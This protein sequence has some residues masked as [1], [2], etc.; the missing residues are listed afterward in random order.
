MKLNEILKLKALILAD[1]TVF[2]SKDRG[3][4]IIYRSHIDAIRVRIEKIEK[5]H[6]E[7]VR[8]LSDIQEH[9]DILDR[10]LGVKFDLSEEE[11]AKSTV[12]EKAEKSPAAG[13]EPPTDD[14]KPSPLLP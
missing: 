14:G 10:K 8:W 7:K 11:S 2:E 12:E 6:A 1:K 13:E 9:R 3:K 4:E 5:S